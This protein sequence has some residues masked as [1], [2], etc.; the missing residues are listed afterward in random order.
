MKKLIRFIIFLLILII[1][2]KA[3]LQL[4][5]LHYRQTLDEA[6]V[7]Y[8]IDNTLFAALVKTESN[9]NETAVSKAGAKGL[10]QITT[11]TAEWCANKMGLSEYDLFNPYDNIEISAFYFSYLLGQFEGDETLA[12]AAYNAGQGNVLKWI[13]TPKYSPDGKTLQNIPFEETEKYIKKINFYQKVYRNIYKI[14]DYIK[15]EM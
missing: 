5:P 7:K 15:K 4:F 11:E 1:A 10:A 3:F 9:F 14:S 6:A 12:L 8:G 13:S 2:L